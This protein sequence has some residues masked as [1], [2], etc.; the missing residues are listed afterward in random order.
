MPLPFRAILAVAMLALW[1]ATSAQPADNAPP[2]AP[3][4]AG[5][6]SAFDGYRRFADQPVQPWRESN[7]LVGRIGGWQ[8]YAREAAAANAQPASAPAASSQSG[9]PGTA[10]AA[11]HDG[12]AGHSRPAAR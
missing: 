9:V 5:E 3:A 12:H 1:P 11:R 6:R 7:E 8:A 10:P 2:A 4:A